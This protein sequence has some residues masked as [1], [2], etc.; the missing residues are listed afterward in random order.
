MTIRQPLPASILLLCPAPTPMVP[1][2]TAAPW[3]SASH[4][5]SKQGTGNVPETRSGCHW[6][7]GSH[8]PVKGRSSIE[9][10]NVAL[11][12]ELVQ[13]PSLEVQ[14]TL[15]CRM[16]PALQS[17]IQS[18]GVQSKPH[19]VTSTAAI[20]RE[21]TFIHATPLP[22]APVEESVARTPVCTH[23]R[24]PCSHHAA[25]EW[26]GGRESPPPLCCS[27]LWPLS[28]STGSVLLQHSR[29]TRWDWR[30][31]TC[32]SFPRA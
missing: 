32:R 9:R 16:L 3:S 5:G 17:R 7:G 4:H 27:V 22:L 30:S 8:S 25:A 20:L 19:T 2:P 12:P 24:M 14:G 15:P 11:V 28:R 10:L 18:Q 31:P 26:E 13:S 23:L 1:F 29:R 6:L 21:L